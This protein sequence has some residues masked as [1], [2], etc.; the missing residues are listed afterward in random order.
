[1]PLVVEHLS[2]YAPEAAERPFF[3]R[4]TITEIAR[5]RDP[6]LVIEGPAD[7]GKSRG[8]LEKLHAAATKYPGMRGAMIRKTRKSLRTTAQVTYERWVCPDGAARLWNDEEYRYPNKSRIYCLGMDDPERV[9]S[10]ELDMAYVQEVSELTEEDYEILTT[11]VTGRGAVMP[12]T[13]LIADM[14]PVDPNFWLYKREAAGNVRFLQARHED[15]PSITPERIAALDRLTGYRHKRLRLGLRVAAEGMYFE[16]WEPALHL[17]ENVEIGKDWPRWITVDYGF[18]VPFCALWLTRSPET[19][20]IYVYRELYATGIRDE[21]QARAIAQAN[22]G[23]RV[24]VVVGDPSMFAERREINLPSIASIYQANGI[25]IQPGTN[26]RKQ[27]WTAVR[28]TLAHDEGAP[29]LQIVRSACPHLVRTLPAMV[30]DPLDPEDLADV[31]NGVKTEDH[32]CLAGWTSIDTKDGPREIWSLVGTSGKVYGSDGRLHRFSNVQMTNERASVYRVTFEDGRTVDATYDHPFQLTSMGQTFWQVAGGLQ[33]RDQVIDKGHCIRYHKVSGGVNACHG[34]ITNDSGILRRA[35]LPLWSLFPT[36]W[37]TTASGRLGDRSRSNSAGVSRSSRDSGYVEEQLSGLGTDSQREAS[38]R[39]F[40]TTNSTDAEPSEHY[41][42][43][44]TGS[45]RLAQV[46]R[47]AGL[48]QAEWNRR[49]EEP[50]ALHID[51]R[52]LWGGLRNAFSNALQ[53][54]RKQLPTEV[55]AD[56]ATTRV[57]QVRWNGYASVYNL[58]VADG[59]SFTVE[60]GLVTHNC[61]ALRYGLM[62]EGVGDQRVVKARFG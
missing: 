5:S 30:R 27:G 26:N 52:G 14:N 20:R 57:R 7:T 28:R 33:P 45:N 62:A 53:V 1:M 23:E 43:G 31:L 41:R 8:C 56:Q 4:G 29:R 3:S 46:S 58:Y 32:A 2:T 24:E 44:D 40:F 34:H 37:A 19:R 54:L 47:G 50:P 51:V 15:N 17:V 25:P 61:D 38:E 48:A 22:E 11:R 55:S 6:E 60:G 35:L 13:Q 21:Q 36:Q 39:S 10:L 49:V 9:K 16:E 59:H 18:A 12:Y 42:E